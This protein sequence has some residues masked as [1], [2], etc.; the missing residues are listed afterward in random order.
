VLDR[1]ALAATGV[2]LGFSVEILRFRLVARRS[3]MGCG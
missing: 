1:L 3:P 2:S